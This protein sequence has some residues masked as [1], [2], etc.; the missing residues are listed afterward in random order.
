[1]FIMDGA[2]VFAWNSFS[3][4]LAADVFVARGAQLMGQLEI[5]AQ[6]NIWFNTV[7]RGDVNYIRIGERTNIQDN[8]TVHVDSRKYP[9]I[10][11]DDV[12]IG[13][14]AIIHACTIGD[15][16]LIGMGSVILDGAVILEDTMVAAGTLIPPGKTYPSKTLVVGRPGKVARALDTH[17]LAWLKG[18]AAHYVKLSQTYFPLCRRGE[19]S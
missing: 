8:T 6:S 3:P 12:T 1:M 7:L 9:T 2:F 14:N 4:K 11:G 10:V 19:I 17:E 16:A 13:H 5:G 15:R 18:S